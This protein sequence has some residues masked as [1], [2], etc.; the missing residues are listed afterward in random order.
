ML[1]VRILFSIVV[2]ACAV[3]VRADNVVNAA[4][5]LLETQRESEQQCIQLIMP[6]HFF[7]NTNTIFK[8]P[9]IQM[10]EKITENIQ[11]PCK[12][13]IFDLPEEI[14]NNISEALPTFSKYIFIER[15][16]NYSKS[17]K[18]P[19]YL[20]RFPHA[21]LLATLN[22]SKKTGAI[23]RLRSILNK[24]SMLQVVTTIEMNNSGLEIEH[25]SDINV[26]ISKVREKTSRLFVG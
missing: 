6:N 15:L 8:W 4:I 12:N 22:G 25:N 3:Q 13:V 14:L 18:A 19:A 7:R 9:L 26:K 24:K 17:L 23:L 2:K 1:V 11:I 20:D 16:F 21:L 5:K 10:N